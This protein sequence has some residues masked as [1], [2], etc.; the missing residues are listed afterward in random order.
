M[1]VL[2]EAL[3]AHLVSRLPSALLASATIGTGVS[4]LAQ[5]IFAVAGATRATAQLTAL[6]LAWPAFLLGFGWVFVAP[7][8][9][10]VWFWLVGGGVVLWAAARILASLS[11]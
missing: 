11:A 1:F 9:G 10:Q 8:L 7:T 3:R 2:A 6:G 4:A 5:S